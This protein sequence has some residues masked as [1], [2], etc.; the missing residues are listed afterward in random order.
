M[1]DFKLSAVKEEVRAKGGGLLVDKVDTAGKL[2][3]EKGLDITRKAACQLVVDC[4]GSMA[5][6]FR[7]GSVTDAIQRVLAFCCIVDDDMAVPVIPFDQSLQRPFEVDLSNFQTAGRHLGPGGTTG[8]HLALRYAVE[9]AGHADVLSGGG[10]GGGLL[11]RFGKGRSGGSG[12]GSS[13]AMPSFIT[14][15]TDGRPNDPRACEQILVAASNRAI[16]W[17]FLF[18]GHDE[19]GWRWLEELDD[20]LRGRH[21]DCIDAKRFG[22]LGSVSDR[23]FYDA[24]LDEYPSWLK[25]AESLGVLTH[26]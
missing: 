26:A 3:I 24:M 23:D 8:L 22:S 9:N 25:T 16:F 1:S 14:V 2:A 11:G 20:N 19:E 6:E 15:I 4:S 5:G 7:S 18:V 17:Q 13:V 10:G 12:S 21:F